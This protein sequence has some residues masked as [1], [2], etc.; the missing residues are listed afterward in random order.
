MDKIDSFH[1]AQIEISIISQFHGVDGVG[2]QS[3]SGLCVVLMQQ[4]REIHPLEI[5]IGSQAGFGGHQHVRV[6]LQYLHH[7]VGRQAQRGVQLLDAPGCNDGDTV[8]GRSQP[9]ALIHLDV[10]DIAHIV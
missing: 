3:G 4:E 7:V 10:F 2:K 6:S 1:A 9:E 5:I 8:K